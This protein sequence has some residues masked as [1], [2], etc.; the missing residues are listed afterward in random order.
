MD[1]KWLYHNIFKKNF[2]NTTRLQSKL[3]ILYSLINDII[4]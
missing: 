3:Q 4:L 2:F 1:D